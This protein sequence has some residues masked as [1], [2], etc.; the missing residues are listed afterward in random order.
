MNKTLVYLEDFGRS[1]DSSIKIELAS[2][3][4]MHISWF[5]IYLSV[6]FGLQSDDK[7]ELKRLMEESK[8]LDKVH[9]F[10]VR[11]NA[12]NLNYKQETVGCL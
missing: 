2:S 6:Y 1:F 8:A 10:Y 7:E 3:R 12:P 11:I 4:S 5:S 9:M